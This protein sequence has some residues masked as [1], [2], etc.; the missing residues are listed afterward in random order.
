MRMY[1]SLTQVKRQ[2]AILY[3]RA[4]PQHKYDEDSKETLGV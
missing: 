1:A 2:I 3:S 4:I